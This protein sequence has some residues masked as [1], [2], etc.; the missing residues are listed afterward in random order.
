[1]DCLSVLRE[2][3]MNGK[4]DQVSIT[5]TDVVFGDGQSFP[6]DTKTA[7][8]SNQG[9]GEYYQLDILVYYMQNVDAPN[10][11]ANARAAGMKTVMFLDRKVGIART[12]H[13]RHHARPAQDLAAYLLGQTDASDFI[14]IADDALL[15]TEPTAKRQRVD[16]QGMHGDLC[17]LTFVF[18]HC[19]SSSQPTLPTLASRSS[20]HSRNSSYATAT[21]CSSS[22]ANR[23]R[24]YVGLVFVYLV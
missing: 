16:E 12:G 17:V 15:D 2:F 6:R 13:V 7:Y 14:V 10:Y 23:S 19:A 21:P 3:A 1:M 5:D 4:L 9:K 11:I 20:W 8:K 24:G 22:L 18:I